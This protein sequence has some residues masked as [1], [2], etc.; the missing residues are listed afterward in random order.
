M[1]H[2]EYEVCVWYILMEIFPRPYNVWQQ[3]KIL[4]I[5]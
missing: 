1:G 4:R 3:K 2:A 5:R